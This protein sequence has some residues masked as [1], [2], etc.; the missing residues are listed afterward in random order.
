M[1]LN[2]AIDK[3]NWQYKNGTLILCIQTQHSLNLRFKKIYTKG[4]L[5]KKIKIVSDR[6]F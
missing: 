6:S 1:L 5:L 3:L 2:S 4:E